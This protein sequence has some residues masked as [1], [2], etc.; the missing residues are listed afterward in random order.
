LLNG[1][2]LKIHIGI[3][4]RLG[5]LE[6][7]GGCIKNEGEYSKYNA[8]T[9]FFFVPEAKQKGIPTIMKL[10]HGM[11]PHISIDKGD[12]IIFSSS[13][14]PGNEKGIMDAINRLA[15]KGAEIIYEGGRRRPLLWT[16]T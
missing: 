11:H 6:A 16:R 10:S 15:E 5:Y 2:N 4:K 8:K 1:T 13:Q 9:T 7:D 12:L 14:I 3:A